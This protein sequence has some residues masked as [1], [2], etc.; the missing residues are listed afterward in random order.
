MKLK[1]KSRLIELACWVAFVLLISL[2]GNLA[3]EDEVLQGKVL[4]MQMTTNNFVKGNNY[5]FIR[6]TPC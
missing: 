4:L 6:S 1:T 5:D 2:A 3:Y